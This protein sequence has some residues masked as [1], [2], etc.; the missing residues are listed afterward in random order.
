MKSFM[1]QHPVASFFVLAYA[2]SWVLWV[3]AVLVWK[4]SDQ[5]PW[6]GM[7]AYL[8]G[9][10]APTFAALAVTGILEGKPGVKKLLARFLVWRVGLRWYLVALLLTP[11]ALLA[12]MGIYVL[13]G[14]ALGRFD[15]G[16]WYAVLLGP[17]FALPF[18]V[19]EELG[20]RG[21]ALPKLQR[22]YSA[23]WS[24]II[25]GVLWTFWHTPAFWA[26]SGTPISGGP[27]T[28]LAVGRYVILMIGLTILMTWLY[29]NT[30]ESVLLAVLFHAVF[31]GPGLS[32]LFP[33]ISS[34]AFNQIVKLV[35]IPLWVMVVLVIAL[36]GAARLSRKPV[37]Q[38]PGEV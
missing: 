3:P 6:W 18:F 31:T 30:K 25:L 23:L 33:D 35:I 16:Q 26:P 12:A 28:L 15:A 7:P 9:T 10:F 8:V 19:G 4:L 11:V 24:S 37:S 34:N 17:V 14:G 22:K 20:W 21:Y 2:I 32:P 29:N 13:Q 27:V 1:K 38:E 5:M 36:F